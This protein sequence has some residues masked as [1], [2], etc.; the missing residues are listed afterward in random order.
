[1]AVVNEIQRD[2]YSYIRAVRDEAN[3]AVA[4]NKI[5]PTRVPAAVRGESLATGPVGGTLPPLEDV[6]GGVDGEPRVK[7]GPGRVHDAV[8]TDVD[9]TGP[10]RPVFVTNF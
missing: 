8:E 4:V 10:E 9:A 1:M 3:V 2:L 6:P 5:R 7:R